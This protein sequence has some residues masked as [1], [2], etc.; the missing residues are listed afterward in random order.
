M[1]CKEALD[2]KYHYNVHNSA[3]WHI[4]LQLALRYHAG[5]NSI[6][7]LSK[8]KKKKHWSKQSDKGSL[9]GFKD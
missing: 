5:Y 2:T 7:R 8:L 9:R 6:K 4:C 3:I 1:A